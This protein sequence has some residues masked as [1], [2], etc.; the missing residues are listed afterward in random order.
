MA[1]SPSPGGAAGCWLRDSGKI[2]A[3]C[4]CRTATPH[5]SAGRDGLSAQSHLLPPLGTQAPKQHLLDIVWTLD[6]N[7]NLRLISIPE[8]LLQRHIAHRHRPNLIQATIANLQSPTP[9]PE[10]RPR[11]CLPNARVMHQQPN[12]NPGNLA[13]GT[14]FCHGVVF[15]RSSD[16]CY[17]CH[18]SRI[19]SGFGPC[20][21]AWPKCFDSGPW[22]K[23]PMRQLGCM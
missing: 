2:L 19:F 9:P 20:F 21:R 17:R 18:N 11:L 8:R 5:P 4:R 13:T 10:P 15:S 3:V 7:G 6:V 16:R 22:T 14:G 23:H 12:H 1:R